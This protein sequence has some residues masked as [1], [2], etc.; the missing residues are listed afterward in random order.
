VDRIT[1]SLRYDARKIAFKHIV[2]KWVSENFR[3]ESAVRAVKL[4]QGAGV[5]GTQQPPQEESVGQF[6]KRVGVTP[7]TVYRWIDAGLIP[8]R[9]HGPR[10]IRIHVARALEAISTPIGADAPEL[11]RAS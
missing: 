8:A 2:V 6:A 11:A 7:L 5:S 10:M 1:P 3:R 9:R 4:V